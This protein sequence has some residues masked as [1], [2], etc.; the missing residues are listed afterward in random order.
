MGRPA[1]LPIADDSPAARGRL[2]VVAW[3]DVA[4]DPAVMAQ[5]TRLARETVEPNPFYAP[6]ALLPALRAYD[7]AGRCVVLLIEHGNRLT[8]LMPVSTPLAYYGYPVPHYRNWV[9]DHAFLG[10]PLVAPGVAHDFWTDVLGWMD[11]TAG[12]KLFLHLSHLDADGTLARALGDVLQSP[13]RDHAVVHEEERAFLHSDRSSTAYF[14]AALS[15]KKRKELR[16][17]ERRLGEAGT[18]ECKRDTGNEYL[19]AW[20]TDF[21]ALE[22]SGW[23]GRAGSALANAEATALLFSDTLHHAAQAGVLERLSLTLDGKPIAM[24]ANFLTPPGAF[25]FKTAFSEDFARYSPGVL[26]QRHN[27][28]LLDRA[29]IDWC[30]SCAAADHPMIDHIWRERR[31]MVRMSIAIGGTTRRALFSRLLAHETRE[32]VDA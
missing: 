23:K 30:D 12:S 2:R 16:R 26:L 24:L 17:Q 11:G 19:D 1:R 9:H 13:S 15:G 8:G 6:W 10:A 5:W 31:R 27:L 4:N 21:L 20:T 18:L 7:A 29:E 3:Q 32:R 22:R 14:N 28:A 25:A